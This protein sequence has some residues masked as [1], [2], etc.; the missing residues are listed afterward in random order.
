MRVGLESPQSEPLPRA[1]AD[2]T[3]PFRRYLFERCGLWIGEDENARLAG[4]LGEGA[5][6]FAAGDPGAFLAMV[7]SDARSREVLG[8]ALDRLLRADH[9][10]AAAVRQLAPFGEAFAPHL[11]ERAAERG[12][13]GLSIWAVGARRGE[14]ALAASML[15][16]SPMSPRRPIPCEVLATDADGDALAFAREGFFTAEAL[17]GVPGAGLERWFDREPTGF[18]AKRE[19]RDSVR[20]RRVGSEEFDGSAAGAFDVV[21]A[22]AVLPYLDP[23]P[24]AAILKS[25]E[26]SLHP[27]GLV[28]LGPGESA[29]ALSPALRLVLYPGGAVYRKP[30]RA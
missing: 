24:R 29:P 25:F 30:L 17:A 10:F 23:A 16:K 15:L 9:A 12:A 20:A 21:V 19:F 11:M 8:W 7:G 18:R 22:P 3:A 14:T 1:E 6:R 13:P 5:A 27:G 28:F 4:V 26:R 2:A